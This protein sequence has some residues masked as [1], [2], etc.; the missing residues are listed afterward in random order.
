MFVGA[1]K[2]FSAILGKSTSQFQLQILTTNNL[3]VIV[4]VVLSSIDI[5][6]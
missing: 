4:C 6:L 3:S 1:L 5:L 2:S